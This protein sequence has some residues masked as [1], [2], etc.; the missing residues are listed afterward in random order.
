MLFQ[1]EM[2]LPIDI[3]MIPIQRESEEDLDATIKKLLKK[4]KKVFEKAE[5]NIEHAQKKQKEQYDRKHIPKELPLDT[6]VMVENTAQKRE[7]RR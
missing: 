4:R 5:K 2:R 3:E 7:E 1:R 6:E